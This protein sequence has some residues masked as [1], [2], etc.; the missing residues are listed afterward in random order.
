MEKYKEGILKSLTVFE[1]SGIRVPR[2]KGWYNPNLHQGTFL[3]SRGL[4]PHPN[5]QQ[6]R[7]VFPDFGTSVSGHERGEASAGSNSYS[8]TKEEL[9]KTWRKT[10]CPHPSQKPTIQ[11]LLTEAKLRCIDFIGI[12]E[13]SQWQSSTA[14]ALSPTNL[15]QPKDQIRHISHGHP[16]HVI[17][18][19]IK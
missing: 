1:G 11:P 13:R 10:V 9:H 7:R 8:R 14:P 2:K 5:P 18:G 3:P 17:S 6:A 12:K 16:A 19:S 4:L 15:G